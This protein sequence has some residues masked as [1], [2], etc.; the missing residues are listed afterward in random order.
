MI[1]PSIVSASV[2]DETPQPVIVSSEPSPKAEDVLPVLPTEDAIVSKMVAASITFGMIWF[3]DA[4]PATTLGFSIGYQFRSNLWFDIGYT[5]GSSNT[6]R[7]DWRESNNFVARARY[8][9]YGRD[10]F[11]VVLVA[12]VGHSLVK[13]RSTSSTSPFFLGGAG[14]QL[15]LP[16]G[17]TAFIEYVVHSHEATSSTGRGGVSIGF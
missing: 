1:A 9:L 16:K 15:A 7:G 5:K 11:G 4:R 10:S 6:W 2:V 12:G 17:M 8:V 3:P 14:L 13:S